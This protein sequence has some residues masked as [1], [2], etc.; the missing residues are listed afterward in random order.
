MFQGILTESLAASPCNFGDSTAFRMVKADSPRLRRIYIKEADMEPLADPCGWLN[1]TCIN[2]GARLL[3]REFDQRANITIFPSYV[4]PDLRQHPGN[5]PTSVGRRQYWTSNI[6]V[7]PSHEHNHW[8]LIVLDLSQNCI[9]QYDSL[10]KRKRWEE[11]SKVRPQYVTGCVLS[12][13]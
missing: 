5:V 8:T 3:R 6:W 12:Q 4:L 1:E 2:E 10:A 11:D 9:R 13:L 7:I